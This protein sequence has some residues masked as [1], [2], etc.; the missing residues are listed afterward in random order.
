VEFADVRNF[1]KN[2][3]NF[4][5]FVDGKTNPKIGLRIKMQRTKVP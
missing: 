2:S 1:H 5:G 4:S 3:D